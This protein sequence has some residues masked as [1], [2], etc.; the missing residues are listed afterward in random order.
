MGNIIRIPKRYYDD[1][2]DCISECESPKIIKQTKSHYYIDSTPGEEWDEFIER[3]EFYAEPYVDATIENGLWSLVH[4]ARATIK[5]IN[6]Q[7]K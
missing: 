7:K 3:C 4:S 2:R 5:A 1:H 6:A